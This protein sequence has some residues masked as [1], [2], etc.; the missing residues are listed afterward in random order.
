LHVQRLKGNSQGRVALGIV[1]ESTDVQIGTQYGNI[2]VSF[3]DVNADRYG[4]R[5]RHDLRIPCLYMRTRC[6][7]RA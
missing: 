4:R 6:K 1:V 7:W 5:S 3:C 2:D